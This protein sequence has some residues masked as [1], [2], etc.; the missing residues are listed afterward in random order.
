MN[1]GKR[2]GKLPVRVR[3]SLAR[4]VDEDGDGFLS[5]TLLEDPPDDGWPSDCDYFRHDHGDGRPCDWAQSRRYAHETRCHVGVTVI[6]DEPK[7]FE[8]LLIGML[9][10]F[11]ANR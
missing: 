5:G 4:E 11:L 7:V 10:R 3:L 1:L 6:L 9:D 8:R 2:I